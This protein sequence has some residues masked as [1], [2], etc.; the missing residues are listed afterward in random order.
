MD[1][2]F[3]DQAHLL[4][5]L[6][7]PHPTH[8]LPF[9]YWFALWVNL[10][11]QSFS[12]CVCGWIKGGGWIKDVEVNPLASQ[13]HFTALEAWVWGG[14]RLDVRCWVLYHPAYLHLMISY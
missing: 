8:K 12:V 13:V 3:A 7:Q 6:S 5:V 10:P 2:L 4:E 11:A 9:S 1:W 14:R